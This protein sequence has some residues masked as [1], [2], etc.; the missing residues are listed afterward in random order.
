[1]PGPSERQKFLCSLH[2]EVGSGRAQYDGYIE[3]GGELPAEPMP[4]D[5]Q[6]TELEEALEEAR[7]PGDG[8]TLIQRA[9]ARK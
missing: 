8:D 9:G 5:S 7:E 4:G 1:M 2:Q 3:S 6:K